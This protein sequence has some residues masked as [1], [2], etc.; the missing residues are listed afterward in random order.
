MPFQSDKHRAFMYANAG[1]NGMPT[2]NEL[3]H[4][5]LGGFVPQYKYGNGVSDLEDYIID[6]GFTK[7]QLSP[8]ELAA[9]R[10]WVKDKNAPISKEDMKHFKAVAAREEETELSDF[11]SKIYDSYRIK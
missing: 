2:E 8:G 9:F 1:K 4:W 10:K 5:A 7:D 3:S 6:G 11:F